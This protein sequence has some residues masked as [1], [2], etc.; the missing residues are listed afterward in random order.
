MQELIHT[1]ILIQLYSLYMYFQ[2]IIETVK[3]EY[4]KN[5]KLLADV[6]FEEK[7]LLET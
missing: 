2:K 6:C 7:I 4:Y 3:R 5:G 1:V